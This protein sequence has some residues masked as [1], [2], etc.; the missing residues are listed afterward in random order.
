MTITTYVHTEVGAKNPEIELISKNYSGRRMLY[1]SGKIKNIKVAVVIGFVDG[2]YMEF[3]D[4][5]T[6]LTLTIV[7]TIDDKLMKKDISK[8]L[9]KFNKIE[10]W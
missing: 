5:R 4:D 7:D 9:S 8:N 2:D 1:R 3:T 6:G 10:F